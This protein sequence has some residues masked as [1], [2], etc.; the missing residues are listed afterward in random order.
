MLAEQEQVCSSDKEEEEGKKFNRL[1]N[2]SELTKTDKPLQD[3]YI[4]SYKKQ[5]RKRLYNKQNAC[6]YCGKLITVLMGRHLQRVHKDEPA[7]ARILALQNGDRKKHLDILRNRGNF[8]HNQ[9]V[10][11][12]G[13]GE[14]ILMRRP[15]DGKEGSYMD[16]GPCP[17]CLGY[18][19]LEDMWRHCKYRCTAKQN[20]E[21]NASES[22]S[23]GEL[24]IQSEILQQKLSGAS[25]EL[26]TKVLATMRSSDTS[27]AAKSD[28]CIVE[29]GN[30][31]IRKVGRQR[32]DIVSAK[33]LLASKL[34][35]KLRELYP[36]EGYSISD[37]LK[38]AY[39]DSILQ[40]TD[41]LGEQEV[42]VN[43]KTSYNKPSVVLKIGHDLKKL[44]TIK[45]CKALRSGDLLMEREAQAF[46]T[47]H[48][49]E[50][51]I[52]MSSTALSTIAERK[53]SKGQALPNTEDLVKLSEYVT[54]QMQEA[55][56]AL[57]HEVNDSTYRQLQ[58]MCLV[59]LLLFN[60][61][62]PGELSQ[63]TIQS[64]KE[65]PNWS[66]SAICEV[67]NS[68]SPLEE[69]LLS[70]LDLVYIRGKRGNAVPVLI[71]EAC[72]HALDMIIKHRPAVNVSKSNI[73]I[74]AVMKS[75]N[76]LRGHDCLAEVVK[77]VPL[78]EPEKIKSTNMR[79]YVATISQLLSMDNNELD[80][81]ARH[82]GHDINIHRQFYRLHE[83]SLELTK[84]AK[85]LMLTDDGKVGNWTGK[86]L[87]DLTLQGTFLIHS[88]QMKTHQQ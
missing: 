16:Y 41:S 17:K 56:N 36:N 75:E 34:L 74:F 58:K 78:K 11:E 47:L 5:G 87:D 37:F 68:L 4:Q 60:K 71:P 25:E 24:I 46:L 21:T 57:D 48:T 50:W 52:K 45:L 53:F 12:T 80:W 38:P 76:Y 79:K 51:G 43:G 15:A 62:R 26:K 22:E 20:E 70:T 42:T 39:F 13:E 84:V 61:R 29:L 65:R 73:Y 7:V 14:I 33:M 30:H 44:A 81:L 23:K 9:R 54:I 88:V 85:L 67:R 59:R 83:S 86:K 19:L 6:L 28:D 32:K 8:Y 69:K 3:I 27:R 82:L 18:V 72:K 66:E 77:E 35:L 40:A 2:L 49:Q 55:M 31:W 10:L 63:M 1:E 64:F